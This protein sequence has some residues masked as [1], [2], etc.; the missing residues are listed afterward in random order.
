VLGRLGAFV[1][2]LAAANESLQ[3]ALRSQPA[4]DFDVEAVAE[5]GAH[6][7]MDLACGVLELRDENAEAA[8]EAALAGGAAQV[9]AVLPSES[10]SDSS[11]E[12]DDALGEQ[13]REEQ[14]KRA[15][16]IEEL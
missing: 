15:R 5:G 3:A 1:P 12:E 4:S 6:V 16:R 9:A 2:Q 10:D 13:E 7:E 8:A 14:G 11:D